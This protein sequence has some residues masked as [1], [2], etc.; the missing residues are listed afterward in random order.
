MT[1]LLLVGA[2]MYMSDE[3]REE[4]RVYLFSVTKVKNMSVGWVHGGHL[5]LSQWDVTASST[6]RP[7]ECQGLDTVGR[8]GSDNNV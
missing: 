8:G 1:D 5:Q 4:G 6:S 7:L 3:K 2:P